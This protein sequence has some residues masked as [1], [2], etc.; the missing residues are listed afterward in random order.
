M[1]NHGEQSPNKSDRAYKENFERL[2]AS[3][4]IKDLRKTYIKVIYF[5]Y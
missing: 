1:E 2:I 3:I 4:V 5:L